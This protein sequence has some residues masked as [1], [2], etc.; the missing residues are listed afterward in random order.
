M[1]DVALLVPVLRAVTERYPGM[2]ITVATRPRFAAF[3]A[4]IP[5][6]DVFAADVNAEYKGIG[7]LY[8][9]YRRLSSFKD[10]DLIIDEHDHLRTKVLR[11]FFRLT[12][13]RVVVFEKGRS[14]KKAFARKKNKV[15]ARLPHTVERYRDA[16]LKANI[17]F[18]LLPP[19]QFQIAET[20][21]DAVD[22]WLLS[23]TV[24]HDRPWIGIAPFA[25]HAT[26]IWPTKN[27]QPLM[28]SILDRVGARFFFFGGGH[29]EITFFESLR[30]QFPD[31][32]VVVAGQLKLEQ[33]IELIRQ[34]DLMICVDSSNM[35]LAA[36]AGTPIVSIWGGTHPD[37]GFAPWSDDAQIIQITRSELPC[38][39][40]SV[41]GRETCYVGGFPCLTRI[42]PEVV[43]DV[44]IAWISTHKPL[45]DQ[46]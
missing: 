30:S 23:R 13:Q 29:S 41:Y 18:D 35:H 14:E 38:R 33:E 8:R 16:F 45:A 24:V 26:K 2:E 31:D 42:E 32:A 9:L 25:M 44:V 19:P 28:R 11:T 37:I 46:H 1:G 21:R 6:V 39:P 22:A 17:P 5:G 36:L 10:F 12:S 3:F 20:T 27:Y 40:C 43:A 34:L 7:G 15:I 4:H